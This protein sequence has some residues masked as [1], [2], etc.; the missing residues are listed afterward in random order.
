[1][2]LRAVDPPLV[3]M[4]LLQRM[5]NIRPHKESHSSNKNHIDKNALKKL[6]FADPNYFSTVCLDLGL[7]LGEA[8]RSESNTTENKDLRTINYDISLADFFG[9]VAPNSTIG[10]WFSV[11][12]MQ[13]ILWSLL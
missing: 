6:S 11:F 7:L 13:N 8:T 3:A 2:E 1:M 12:I 5:G 9:L 10:S 4:A